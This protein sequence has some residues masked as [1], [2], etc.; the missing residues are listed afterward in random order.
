MDFELFL[1]YNWMWATFVAIE[2][3]RGW[4]TTVD[5]VGEFCLVEHTVLTHQQAVFEVSGSC[6]P[7][8]ATRATGDTAADKSQR[9]INGGLIKEWSSR[10]FREKVKLQWLKNM[11]VDVISAD[12]YKMGWN[13]HYTWLSWFFKVYLLI[14]RERERACEQGREAEREREGER[15]SSRFHSTLSM[16]TQMGLDL[17]TLELKSRVGCLTN[18]TTQASQLLWCFKHRKGQLQT[19]PEKNNISAQ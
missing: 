5:V 1:L 15:I 18:W 2:H 10:F 7:D 16:E 17:T 4:T 12:L 3:H 14:L 11:F 8:Q 6:V 9:C 19:G 13:Y